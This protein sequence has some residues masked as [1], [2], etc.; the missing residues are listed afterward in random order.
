[1]AEKQRMLDY[2]AGKE[3]DFPNEQEEKAVV[4]IL[5]LAYSRCEMLTEAELDATAEIF[6]ALTREWPD[7]KPPRG[8]GIARP[9]FLRLVP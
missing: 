2:A 9:G 1:M 3:V 4:A 8:G 5:R 6:E 7:D